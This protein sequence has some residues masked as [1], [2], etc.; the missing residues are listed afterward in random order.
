MLE[1]AE[2]LSNNKNASIAPVWK[3]KNT[4]RNWT[5]SLSNI[6]NNLAKELSS[7]SNM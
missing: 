1:I 6:Y 7:T 3:T 4:A 2:E 5:D